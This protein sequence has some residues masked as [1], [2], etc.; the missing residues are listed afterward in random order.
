M[1]SYVLLHPERN[2]SI[3]HSI[4]TNFG[5]RLNY[6]HD[7][8]D[9]KNGLALRQR[10]VP[11]KLNSIWN[12]CSLLP[13]ENRVEFE[14]IR[15][16]MVDEVQ[17]ESN[18]EWLWLL[19]LIE[20]SW[21]ILRYRR[22]KQRVLE[23]SRSNAIE[24][25]LLRLDGAGVPD[26]AS[27]DAR[28]QIRRN[29]ADWRVDP[30]AAA[31]I[32]A[33]LRQNGFGDVAINAEVYCHAQMAFGMF[34]GLIQSAQARRIALLREISFRREFKLRVE[35]LIDASLSPDLHSPERSFAR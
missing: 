20:L 21:E 35:K 27:S 32:E 5:Q 26:E 34:D 29:V 9:I 30:G 22:L 7:R 19:D 28:L 1:R 12:S 4:R 23:A 3:W 8:T 10:A 11:D 25:I 2:M 16:M 31:E 17:P 33:R 24:S 6:M 13:G 14:T 15:Q 18:L